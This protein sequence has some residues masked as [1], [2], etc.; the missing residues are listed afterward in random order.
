[1]SSSDKTYSASGHEAELR[2]W[3]IK[4]QGNTILAFGRVYGDRTGRWPDGH[5]IATSILE[6]GRRKE[7]AVIT[8]RNNRYLLAGP[9]GDLETTLNLALEMIANAVRRAQ[10]VHDERYFD[11]LPA[12]WGMDDETFEKVANLPSRW[13]F[14]WRN[15][16]RAP[17]DDELARIRRLMRFHEAIRFVTYGEPNYAGWWRRRWRGDSCIGRRSPREAVL[18]D[19]DSIMDTLE[20]CFR[21]QTR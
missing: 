13:L 15:Y 12:A 9:P 16:Y 18:A 1:M 3:V 10:A 5:A 19:G 8:T 7:G 20:L 11:L 14:Q 6:P 17:S 21:S 2:E 4:A